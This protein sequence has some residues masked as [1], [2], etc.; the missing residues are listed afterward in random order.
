VTGTIAEPT[1]DQR[2]TRWPDVAR[3]AGTLVHRLLE[4]GVVG[5]DESD[6]EL[7]ARIGSVVTPGERDRDGC[8]N[9]MR[10]AAHAMRAMLGRPAVTTLL[11]ASEQWHELPFSLRRGQTV[12]H[13][14]I[15]SIV[16]TPDGI[17]VVEF[18]TGR[19]AVEHEAQVELYV[20]AAQEL[21]PGRPVRGVII[22]PDEDVW[23]ASTA[24]S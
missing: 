17:V 1:F 12:F 11:H 24:A 10:E 21:F 7:F 3:L 4:R 15:D 16:A 13:G 5:V 23:L 14:S 19:R 2:G 22:Y 9:A 6:T 8:E 18:K 20:E